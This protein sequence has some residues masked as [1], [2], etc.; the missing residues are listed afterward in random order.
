MV[1]VA[2]HDWVQNLLVESSSRTVLVYYKISKL[3]PTFQDASH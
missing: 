2:V 3:E 1:G